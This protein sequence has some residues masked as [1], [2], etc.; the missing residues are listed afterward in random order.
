[1]DALVLRVV[2]ALLY[3]AVFY[4]LLGLQSAPSKVAIFVGV[5]ATL[6]ITMGAL[7]MAITAGAYRRATARSSMQCS[8]YVHQ[9]ACAP[10]SR[11]L[12]QPLSLNVGLPPLIV[13]AV[14]VGVS[15]R[16]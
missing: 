9:R 11:A 16:H 14:L 2:P 7:S 4:P 10:R 1:M 6:S 13:L 15:T 8:W 12:S 5:L 3:T